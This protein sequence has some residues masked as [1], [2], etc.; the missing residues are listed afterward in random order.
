[1]EIQARVRELYKHQLLIGVKDRR[2]FD[3][4]LEERLN[5]G[6]RDLKTWVKTFYPVVQL[7]VEEHKNQSVLKCKDIRAYYPPIQ[8]KESENAEN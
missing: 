8:T 4:P 1:M 6:I 2:I 5:D 3:R 7:C